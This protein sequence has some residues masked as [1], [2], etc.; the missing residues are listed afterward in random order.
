MQTHFFSSSLKQL[1]NRELLSQT[2]LLI[3]KERNLHIQILTHLKEIHSRKLYLKMGFSSLFDYCH[4]ELDYSEGAAYRR[5]QAMK[6]CREL[7]ETESH[8]QTGKLSLTVASELQTFFERKAKEKTHLSDKSF[9]QKNQSANR[10]AT[11][12]RKLFRENS[13]EE[14]SQRKELSALPLNQR[15]KRELIEKAKGHSTRSIRKLLSETDPSLSPTPDHIRFPA[16]GKVEIK[17]TMD[18]TCYKKLEELKN[19]LSHKNPNLSY[20]GLLAI[21]SEEG[22]NRHDPRRK[23]IRKDKIQPDLGKNSVESE[24]SFTSS[25]KPIISFTKESRTSSSEKSVSHT[26]ELLTSSEKSASHIKEPL[27]SSEKSASHTKELLTSSEKSASHTKEL[28]TS[29]EKSASHI[30]ELLTSSEKSGYFTKTKKRKR[31]ISRHIPSY[32]RKY[33]W[34]RDGGRCAYVH[35]ETKRRCSSKYLL[36]IDHIQPFALGGKTEK[37]N[38]RLLCAAHNQYRK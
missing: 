31:I 24:K 1:G 37:E 7:P 15:Q 19:L 4:K 9:P 2:K 13:P 30:K 38:L 26:K 21:L 23:K 20:G 22:L 33:I 16:K 5:I 36:Q 11:Q 17:I 32:L 3:Q 25:R 10:N 18:E 35:G 6:L 34:K 27:T 29:S 28:L 14:T 8:L 12:N